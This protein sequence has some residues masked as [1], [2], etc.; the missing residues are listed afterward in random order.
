MHESSLPNHLPFLLLHWKE[1][2]SHFLQGYCKLLEVLN[3]Y[4]FTQFHHDSQRR[5]Q[6]FHNRPFAFSLLSHSAFL[7]LQAP[8]LYCQLNKTCQRKCQ[9]RIYVMIHTHKTFTYSSLCCSLFKFLILSKVSSR[10]LYLVLS[11]ATCSR[12]LC[13]VYKSV[14]I[15][16]QFASSKWLWHTS[17]FW[18]M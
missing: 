11:S 9:F 15:F 7:I 16:S 8:P 4:H 12:N 17:T 2:F 18:T 1:N 13:S 14:H 10:P 5:L 6:W 3:T